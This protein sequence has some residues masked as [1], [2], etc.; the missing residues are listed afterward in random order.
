MDED[1]KQQDW[2]REFHS[3]MQEQGTPIT[4]RPIIFGKPVDLYKLFTLV[5][6]EGGYK[7]VI[8]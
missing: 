6:E 2:L 5:K 7:K 1:Q 3:F 4:L 8:I